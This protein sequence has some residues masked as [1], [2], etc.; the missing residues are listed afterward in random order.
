[1]NIIKSFDAWESKSKEIFKGLLCLF[2]IIINIKIVDMTAVVDMTVIVGMTE[3]VFCSGMHVVMGDPLPLLALTWCFARN[4]L[5][6]NV[7]AT[8]VEQSLQR[9]C[10]LFSFVID[11]TSSGMTLFNDV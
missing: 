4:N 1:M 3:V 11:S 7:M 5:I 10:D 6:I 9:I 8:V 2:L